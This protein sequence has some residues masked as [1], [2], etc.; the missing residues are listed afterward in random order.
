MCY[1]GDICMKGEKQLR[2][3]NLI[4]R[5]LCPL[6][7]LLLI[8]QM[9]VPVAARDFPK[10]WPTAPEIADETGI[11]MEASTGQILFDKGMDEVRY[12]AST[13][14]VMTALL[15]LENIEDLNEIITFTDVIT[16]DLEPGNSTI[17]AKVGEQL[18]VEQ[19]L[20]AI[21]L[22]S[23]NEV[24]TQMAVRVAGSVSNFTAMMNKRAAELGCENTHFVNANG[25]PDPNHYTTAHDLARILAAA[26]ANEDFCKIS[27]AAQYT[28]PATNKTAAPRN[29]TNTNALIAEGDSHYEGV[30]AG[31][32]GHTEA[33]RN[34]LVTAARRDNM[35]L[36]CVVMR[37]EGKERF[38][39]TTALF[40]YGFDQFHMDPVYWMD[41]ETP[42]GYAVL[43]NSV[44]PGCMAIA[45]EDSS[46]MRTRTYSY[47]GV[48]ILKVHTT[49]PM[50]VKTRTTSDMSMLETGMSEI[51]IGSSVVFPVMMVLL[52]VL[53][54]VLTAVIIK[55]VLD[56][57]RPKRKKKI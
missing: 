3:K 33:A 18:T 1:T 22:A 16:P 31:K 10:S 48:E 32:T 56:S 25:L 46:D 17:D 14:K 9:A 23:A 15:I 41:E 43:P 35:T 27:G 49:L 5:L 36:I 20:Y 7:A 42:A 44:T 6:L 11:L 53:I 29:L 47:Q 26:V 34:T 38:I 51:Q 24:C 19:C 13:T 55:A 50:E 57:K 30:I 28:I 37:S 45:E 12:P 52:A 54:I 8:F 2:Q 21:M 39:D 40:D 4:L